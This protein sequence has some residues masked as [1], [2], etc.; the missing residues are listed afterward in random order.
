MRIKKEY[1][2]L[3]A[4][5]LGLSVYLWQHT[6][7]QVHYRLP[8][9]D[10]IQARDITRMV[11]RGPQ[12]TVPLRR[13]EDGTWFVGSEKHRADARKAESLAEKI[14]GLELT[15]LV[16]RSGNFERYD[17]DEDSR[18]RVRAWKGE[19]PVRT[20]DV[21]KAAPNYSSTYV[22][23]PENPNVYLARQN[24]RTALNKD[25]SDLRDK[26]VLSFDP[27]GIKRIRVRGRNGSIVRDRNASA[28]NG[29][30]W[31]EEG[32]ASR[33]LAE[34]EN[35]RC[36]NYLEA[37]A[38]PGSRQPAYTVQVSGTQEHRVSLFEKGSDGEQ[39]SDAGK[40]E[41]KPDKPWERD[42]IGTS[43]DSPQPFE[44]SDHKERKLIRAMETILGADRSDGGK[45]GV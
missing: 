10:S 26:R 35:L 15:A 9:L 24:L 16:S 43:T 1:L 14:A 39:G 11:I 4:V 8:E 45:D 5:I 37:D 13:Q 32:P 6:S 28:G 7:D 19:Q 36:A 27:G 41:K 3:V 44:L 40:G 21:G 33:L 31:P 25:V 42:Y 18:I 22:K 20:L 38:L 34:L 23:L 30:A 2:V 12:S 29:T 17:L